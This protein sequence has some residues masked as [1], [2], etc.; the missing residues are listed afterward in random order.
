MFRTTLKGL[1]AHKVRLAMT[2]L[3]VS[4]GVAFLA[5]TLVLNATMNQTFDKLFASVYGG[6]DA[7]VRE[8]AA[9][10]GPQ[11]T[12]Q[13]RGRVDASLVDTVKQVDGVAN[14]EGIVFGTARIVDKS[15]EAM[16]NPANGA[17]TIGFSWPAL[18]QLNPFV[19]SEGRAPQ[20]DDE[21]VI[22]R[23]S[24]ND[25]RFA[26]GDTI[27]VLVQG[28]PQQLHLVGIAKF[29]DADSPAGATCV[30]FTPA[31]AQRLVGE[32]NK[33]DE[34]SILADRG[35]SQQTLT[36]R[37]AK[38][39]PGGTEAL[40]G[41]QI[42]KETQSDI[43][44]AMSFFNTFM[45]VFA[46]V[47]L[48]VGAFMIFNTF[49]ITVAQRTRESAL[50][51]ALGASKRQILSSVVIEAIVVGLAA[52]IVGL[53]AGVA[54]AQGLKVMIKAI[55]F[56]MPGGSVVFTA[57][58]A[59]VSLVVGIAITVVA[60][61]SPARKAAKVPPVAAMQ[62]VFVGSTGYGS[63][64]RI[65]V[66]AGVLGLGIGAL[67]LGLFGDV[68]NALSIVG[69]GALLVF[70]GV[71]ILGR[72]VS[73][74]LSRVLGWPVRKLR[75]L[76]GE[77]ARENAMRNPKRTAASASALMIGV[78]LVAFITILASSTT[79]SI[80]ATVD[81][82]FTGDFAIDPGAGMNG[83]VDPGLATKLNALPQVQA[84][85]GLRMGIAKLNGSVE[86][87]VG[88][89]PNTAFDLFD[90]KVMEGSKS[91][92]NNVDTIAIYKDVARD[93]H[94]KLGDKMP[95]VFK[96]SGDKQL[97][98]AL[99]YGENRPAGDYFLG[100]PTY[101]A[102][103]ANRYDM[104]VF[105]KKAPDVRTPDAMAAVKAVAK[106][107][108]GVTVLDQQGYK[109]AQ[110]APINQMLALV[111]A[112]L[113]LAIVI[114]LL[115]IG[116]TL[117]L[118]IFERTHELG[119][120]RAVGMTRSQLRATIRWESVIIAMQGTALGMLIGLFF[121]WSLVRALSDQGIDQFSAP[122]TSLA[123]VVVLA[124]LAGVVA[125]IL[126]GRRA[127]KLDVLKAIVTE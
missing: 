15:G 83:G 103:F 88:V 23:K 102:N 112:L 54:V 74:P 35:V 98:V 34:I 40:T 30:L 93:K 91:D 37:V 66:G 70:F 125:A 8:K 119:L 11:N 59:I 69:L 113:A 45:L 127:A 104:Q 117:A 79:A 2:A 73:L 76:T 92:L 20:A 109:D 115:G 90:P 36:E 64:Q 96:D 43:K 14:A 21:I 7:V 118:S 82:A 61:L 6:T 108:P 33:Y 84:A 120:L 71:S 106:Q 111:Y 17:P 52:S 44:Q 100:M 12:G 60:A 10:E 95:A 28:P 68:D 62:S 87:L 42:I 47:D 89:D 56:D 105:A 116:N 25:G 46:A 29:G 101:E 114:A 85:T 32:P 1:V 13:Q 24:A 126:P 26:V 63:K 31:A 121:G 97:T 78:G 9:F 50:L 72:T 58:T 86:M 4:L 48:L 5:G 39:I 110:A 94:L 18:P 41:Q 123:V 49:S 67:F 3:A 55:G 99:I 65:I 122:I 19:L 53:F 38:V 22:D 107:Y 124:W 75:G 16:G 81:R 80:N 27:T 77:L 51:R 57:N